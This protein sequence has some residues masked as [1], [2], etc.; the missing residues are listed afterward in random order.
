M[1][2]SKVPVIDLTCHCIYVY[3]WHV[4]HRK[5]PGAFCPYIFA[6]FLRQDKKVNND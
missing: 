4:A 6:T 3:A 2:Q 1:M 5:E